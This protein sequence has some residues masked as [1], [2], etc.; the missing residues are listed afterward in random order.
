MWRLVLPLLVLILAMAA[1]LGHDRP[2]PRA[3]FTFVNRG[4]ISTLDPHR[5]S[6]LQDI[7]MGR[8][9]YEGLV[10]SDV[11]TRDAAIV[12]GVA[13]RWE[14]SAD[15]TVYTFHLRP[16]ARWS[17]G[18]PVTAHDFVYAWRRA[19]LP[20]TA[21]DYIKYF[22]LIRGAREFSEWRRA[23]LEQ[24]KASAAAAADRAAASS[25]LWQETL[26]RFDETVAVKAVED[27]V[28]RVE[29]VR[30][31]PYW[32]D[33]CAFVLF[34]PLYPPAV[35]RFERVDPSTGRLHTDAGW[36]RPPAAVTNGPFLIASWRF[37]REVRLEKNP[38]WW[39]AASLNVDSISIPTIEDPSA[40]VVAFHSGAVDWV[41][42]VT[43]SYRG[44]MLEAKAAF[45]REHQAEVDRLRAQGL[46]PIEID[47]RL[48]RDPRAT[49]H[50]FPTFGTY[51]YNFNCRPRLE[52]GREN[53]FAD[54]RVRRA[55]AMAVDREH[56]ARDLRRIGEPPA[57]TLI[58][59]GSLPGYRSPRGL[60][61][62]PA[63]ARRL[64][65]EAGYPDG[66]GFITVEILYNKDAGQDVIAQAIA[67]DWERVLG[68]RTLLQQRE[69]HAF[70]TALKQH[71][72]MVSRASWFGDYGDPTTFL[73][74]H[75][76]GD[77]N[78]DRGYSCAEFDAI[79]DRAEEEPDPDRRLRILEQAEAILVERDLPV[80]PI[81]HY[82]SVQLFDAHRVSGITSH[83]RQEQCLFR[84]DVL[85]DGKGADR[86]L[87][88][89]PAPPAGVSP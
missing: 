3:D 25:S 65:A 53:P 16:G 33:L 72:F 1:L 17:N 4:D 69:F 34:S 20:D 28:L 83:P 32:L 74:P 56:V 13:E 2:A 76:T 88:L 73:D 37:K 36:T 23:A 21:S 15:G 50:T 82:S 14:V 45:Y 89:P 79:L 7:R 85:G 51:F 38:Y 12:P 30:R 77:G 62:D 71:D 10:R 87:A 5:M 9:L 26:R 27:R 29:L 80:V 75:R 63:A 52:D 6:W 22:Q 43:P 78:N 18:E 19:I 81:Y 59:P 42:D 58:P 54:A 40:S 31:V 49:I 86:P 70:R 55:F 44:D 8:A 35:D 41:T 67:R 68:V 64:L 66:R 60:P 48:P 84:I 39:D 11:F 24:F 61:Y 57:T 47:R 46:D